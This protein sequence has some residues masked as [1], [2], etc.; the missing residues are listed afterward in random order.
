[1]MLIS[2][3]YR[4]TIAVSVIQVKSSKLN[5]S[6]I[7]LPKCTKMFEQSGLRGI[8]NLYIV[9]H[10]SEDGSEIESKHCTS[11]ETSVKSSRKYLVR[12]S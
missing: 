11:L 8:L 5:L 9:F 10:I 12:L 7:A 4:T 2:V 3:T 1:M 6:D